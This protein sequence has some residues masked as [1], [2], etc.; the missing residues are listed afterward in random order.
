MLCSV[1]K[2]LFYLRLMI[3]DLRLFAYESLDYWRCGGQARPHGG[4]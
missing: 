2:L 1:P 3:H 4:A